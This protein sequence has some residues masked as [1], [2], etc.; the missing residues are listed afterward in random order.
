MSA[1]ANKAVARGYIEQV[2]NEHRPDLVEKYMSED[3][4]HHDDPL[5]SDRASV[6]NFIATTLEAFPDLKISIEQEIAEGDLVVQ[7][8]TVNGTQ[9]GALELLGL[10]ATGKPVSFKSVY[11]FRV[12]GGKIAEL[13]G[14]TDAMSM[15]QQLGVIPIP[16]AG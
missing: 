10:P 15:M 2:W 7:R 12:A 13:W 14:V 4:L 5:V 16:G 11:V 9:T 3:F 1:E 8:Q 6:K